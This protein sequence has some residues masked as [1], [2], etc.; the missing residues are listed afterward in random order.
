[1]SQIARQLRIGAYLIESHALAQLCIETLHAQHIRLQ[2][3]LTF[4]LGSEDNLNKNPIHSVTF[5]M[6]P[7]VAQS[8]SL[9]TSCGEHTIGER[10]LPDRDILETYRFD[11]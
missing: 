4:F 2:L 6:N 10:N 9:R 1:M 5:R 7:D 11:T 8:V 3:R